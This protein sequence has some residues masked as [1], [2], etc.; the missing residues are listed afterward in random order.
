[1]N[2]IFFI[3]FFSLITGFSSLAC[4]GFYINRDGKIYAGNNED[5]NNPNTKMWIIP[6]DNENYGKILF[7]FDDYY[8]QGGINEKGLFFDGFATQPFPVTKSKERLNYNNTFNNILN[9][10]LSTCSNVDEVISF[11]NKYNLDFL[12]SSMLFFGDARGNSIIVEGDLILRKE[13]DFQVV[14]NFRQ[15]QTNLINNLDFLEV[16]NFY[17]SKKNEVTCRRYITVSKML[18]SNKNITVDYCRDILDSTHADGVISTLYSQVYDIKNMKIHIYNFHN[19]KECVIIDIKEELKKGL[20]HYDLP[21]LFTKSSKYQKFLEGY[22]PE[23]KEEIA[24]RKMAKPQ[25][26]SDFKGRYLLKSIVGPEESIEVDSDY[27]ATVDVKDEKLICIA[28][29]GCHFKCEFLQEYSNKFFYK[30]FWGEI[31][32]TFPKNNEEELIYEQILKNNQK[33]IWT[34]VKNL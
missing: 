21:E 27:Y 8:P 16:A 32:V 7:G 12:E 5:Y 24:K 29:Y 2:K 23:A 17:Q 1:M 15:S 4:T 20:A 11:L 14:T 10:I 34:W 9:E 31:R 26:N 33:Y 30:F 25:I 28:Q 3:L 19:F 6:G 22:M 18:S 13:K